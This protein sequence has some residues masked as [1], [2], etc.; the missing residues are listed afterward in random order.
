MG[1]RWVRRGQATV[2]AA[3]LLPTVLTLVALL[4]QPACVLYTKSVMASAASEVTRLAATARGSDDA[5]RA[6]VLRRLAAV[7]DL[8][9]FHEGGAGAW[10]VRTQG[11]DDAGRV[12][13]EV[14]GRVSPLPL[15]GTIVSALG[16]A[17][18]GGVVMRVE[19]T[20]DVRADWIGGGYEDWIGIWG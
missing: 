14:E 15:L 7:P 19:V 13:V 4:V 18:G 16:E 12:T 9:V 3:L 11:P 17:D 20:R 6:Y 5:V 10:E 8:G 2:E 1:A